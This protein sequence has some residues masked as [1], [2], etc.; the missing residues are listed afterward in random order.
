[1]CTIFHLTCWFFSFN[2]LPHQY[3]LPL[4]NFFS[5]TPPNNVFWRCIIFRV[6]EKNGVVFNFVLKHRLRN[7]VYW[8][9]AT[10]LNKALSCWTQALNRWNSIN[11]F[12]GNWQIVMGYVVL[13]PMSIDWIKINEWNANWF[14]RNLAIIYKVLLKNKQP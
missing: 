11:A 12:D 4:F 10:K 7:A 14:M 1:M 3:P 5:F 8:A 9:N 13:R 6:I 2:R